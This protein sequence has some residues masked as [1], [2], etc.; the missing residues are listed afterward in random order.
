MLHAV[1]NIAA[2]IFT[3]LLVT[4]VGLTVYVLTLAI[5]A[6]K[7]PARRERTPTNT[8]EIRRVQV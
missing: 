2:A 3:A 6:S 1:V 8:S 7:P 4:P 5:R